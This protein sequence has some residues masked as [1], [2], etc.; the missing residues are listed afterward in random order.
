MPSHRS[1]NRAE[2]RGHAR[3]RQ[4]LVISVAFAALVI[5]GCA[6]KT[7]PISMVGNKPAQA[8]GLAA[9]EATQATIK[10]R[11]D[12]Q[13][14]AILA[15]QERMALLDSRLDMIEYA[16]HIGN[17]VGKVKPPIG[18]V[19]NRPQAQASHRAHKIQP[20]AALHIPPVPRKA[21][22]KPAATAPAKPAPAQA[23]GKAAAKAPAKPESAQAS[24][25]KKTKPAMSKAER[26]KMQKR[27]DDDM[28]LLK[29]G[30]YEKATSALASFIHQYPDTERT[31]EARYWLG[32]ALFA[33]MQVP[34]AV[35]ALK[36]F[37]SMPVTTPKRAPA[38]FRLGAGYQRLG[39]K[40]DA[41]QAFGILRRDYPG[42]I[43]A[44]NAA[45]QLKALGVAVPPPPAPGAQPHSQPQAPVQQPWAVNIVSLDVRQDAKQ[46]LARLHR[47]GLQATM[48]KVKVAGKLWYRLRLTGYASRPAAESERLKII[49]KG[50]ADAWVSPE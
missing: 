25:P 18:K 16:L 34:K 31:P 14:S 11:Q 26:A 24:A 38:L 46:M 39:S 10:S 6:P 5:A 15:M 40:S 7:P 29:S 37:E 21:S 8:G 17:H 12:A 13:D 42:T 1:L 4:A 30:D 33:Q 45:R 2:N 19:G 41:A 22:A 35:D 20:P 47:Q 48:M 9:I 49:K 3:S 23:S 43:E 36:P 32:E 50:Y 44:H 27:F 28:Q